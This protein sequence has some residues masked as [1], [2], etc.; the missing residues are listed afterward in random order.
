[1]KERHTKKRHSKLLWQITILSLTVGLV[2]CGKIEGNKGHETKGAGSQ[3]NSGGA[4]SLQIADLSGLGDVK[5]VNIKITSVTAQSG[6]YSITQTEE[7]TSGKTVVIA[8]MPE[9]VYTVSLEAVNGEGKVVATGV[10]NNVQIKIGS[11]TNL[12]I[13]LSKTGGVSPLVVEVIPPAPSPAPIPTPIPTPVQA[14]PNLEVNPALLGTTWYQPPAIGFFQITKKGIVGWDGC[15]S[16][17]GGIIFAVDGSI[18]PLS[19]VGMSVRACG[20][21]G[22]QPTFLS[23]LPSSRWKSYVL[24]DGK[25]IVTT[26]TGEKHTFTVRPTTVNDAELKSS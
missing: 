26:D 15:N 8:N 21:V 13:A 7:Y 10:A 4:A 6:S 9:R 3:S 5:K 22:K 24:Q 25:L 19:D 18:V 23:S 12:R 2:G 11:P 1:M 20:W 14:V 16:F 17:G